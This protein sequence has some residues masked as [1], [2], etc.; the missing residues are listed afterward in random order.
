M[1]IFPNG[2]GLSQGLSQDLARRDAIRRGGRTGPV[3]ATLAAAAATTL[4]VAVEPA[5]SLTVYEVQV[6]CPVDGQKF[7]ASMVASYTSSGARLDLK[8]VGDGVI[9]PYPYPVCPGN[10]FVVYKSE[11]SDSERAA[12]NAI[13]ASGEFAKLRGEHTDHYMVAYVKQRLGADDF[14]VA[15]SYLQASWEAERDRPQRV[16]EYRAKAL[17][18]FDAARE[19]GNLNVDDW[20]TAAVIGIE[21]KRLAGDFAAAEERLRNLP[22]QKLDTGEDIAKNAALRRIID[23]IALQAFNRNAEPQLLSDEPMGTVGSGAR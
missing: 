6:T 9:A 22:V 16:K 8:P 7:K 14:A 19:R 21:L 23:Q 10:G 13:M 4:F 3:A 1:P 12:I 2:Q 5:R 20:W 15:S 18:K 17:E 11:F